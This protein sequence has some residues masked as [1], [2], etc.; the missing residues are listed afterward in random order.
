MRAAN[1]EGTLPG[2]ERTAS[3]SLR[4]PSSA[5]IRLGNLARGSSLWL[6]E[7]LASSRHV[8]EARLMPKKMYTYANH[9][10]LHTEELGPVVDVR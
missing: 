4:L 9:V 8:D 7:A 2:E 6:A 5:S 1:L 10:G 3:L